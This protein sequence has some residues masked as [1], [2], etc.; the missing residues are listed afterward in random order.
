M[1]LAKAMQAFLMTLVSYNI[2]TMSYDLW[3]GLALVVCNA[4]H[5]LHILAAEYL[6]LQQTL[7][8]PTLVP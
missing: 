2:K 3:W 8:T 7:F 1:I 6:S 4:M 5:M